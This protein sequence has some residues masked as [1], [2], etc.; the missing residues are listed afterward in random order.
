VS[1]FPIDPQ[2]RVLSVRLLVTILLFVI[3]SLYGANPS[4]AQ[5]ATRDSIPG[6]SEKAGEVFRIFPPRISTLGVVYLPR[7]RYTSETDFGFGG[8]VRRK[9]R[10]PGSPAT[11]P[12]SDITLKGMVTTKGQKRAEIVTRI[13]PCSGCF[14]LKAKAQYDEFPLKFWGLGPNSPASLEE[15]YQPRSVLAYVELF[16]QILPRLKIGLRYEHQ[17]LKILSKESSSLLNIQHI[18]GRDG[19]KVTG[20]GILLDWD[21]RDRSESPTRGSYYQFFSLWFDDVFG[22]DSDFNV[23]HL[24][25]RNYFPIS[26]DHVLATQAFLYSAQGAVPFWRYAALGGRAHTRGYRKGRYLDH[27]LVAC[28]V[29]YR[30]PVWKRLGM[31]VFG[32]VGNVAPS[33]GRLELRYT[34]PTGGLGI[35]YQPKASDPLKIRLDMGVGQNSA[36]F[37]LLLDEAF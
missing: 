17:Q 13:L 7:I 25:L 32:G 30:F 21:S 15:L 1:L 16:R 35:R 19:G 20:A 23:Y 12:A 29:E 22:S 10:W 37:Y 5:T 8:K 26:G 3:L 24:D 9:F 11:R 27:T 6:N 2:R 34:R 31:V 14:Y 28:Q 33:L 18:P 36:R 4:R